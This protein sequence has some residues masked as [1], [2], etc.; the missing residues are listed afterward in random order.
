MLLRALGGRGVRP[1]GGRWC[2]GL[3]PSEEAGLLVPLRIRPVFRVWSVPTV[4]AR[5]WRPASSTSRR[6]GR[7]ASRRSGG[8]RQSTHRRLAQELS[9][10]GMRQRVAQHLVHVLDRDRPAASSS[11]RSGMSAGPSRSPRDDARCVMPA[12]CAA[13]IFSLRPPIGST[14]PR[15][16]ISPVIA[17]SLAHRDRAA[18]PTTS[19]VAIVMPAD[20]PSFGMAPSGK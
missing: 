9:G 8:W 16:V 11:T 10:V 19:A 4:A 17:T 3:G 7:A 13:R 18:A 1:A 14:R 12:R 6:A 5:R 15:S 20:G 2:L